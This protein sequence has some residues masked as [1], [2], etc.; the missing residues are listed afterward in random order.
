[1]GMVILLVVVILI[2]SNFIQNI[3][4]FSIF[5]FHQSIAINI[6]IV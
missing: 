2:S 3:Q 1:M 5:S 6:S 4:L